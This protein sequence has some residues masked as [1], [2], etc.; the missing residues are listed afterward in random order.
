MASL[1]SAMHEER[2]ADRRKH[3]MELVEV[4]K[5]VSEATE[6]ALKRMSVALTAAHDEEVSELRKRC[7]ELVAK[8]CLK[9]KENALREQAIARKAARYRA[10]QLKQEHAAQIVELTGL[11]AQSKKEAS[12]HARAKATAAAEVATISEILDESKRAAAESSEELK[13]RLKTSEQARNDM[14]KLLEVASGESEALKRGHDAVVSEL[15]NI[16]QHFQEN[17][18]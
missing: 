6:V 2:D 16:N 11:L 17:H 10:H 5:S 12:L 15:K 18:P 13:K 9:V 4:K 3:A 1:T 14:A 7:N 8:E